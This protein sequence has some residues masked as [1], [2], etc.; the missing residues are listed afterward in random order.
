MRKSILFIIDSLTCGGAEKSLVSLLPLLNMDK[1][2]IY[3]WMRNP[4]GAFMPLIPKNIHI[5]EQPSYNV[6]EKLKMLLGRIAFSMMLRINKLFG[7]VEHGA[8]TLWKCQGWAMKVPKGK[9][10][11]VVAYQQGIVAFDG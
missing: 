4:G 9:W 3:L 11:V 8:E 10:D 5:V 1:Y 6:I 2:D 7:K